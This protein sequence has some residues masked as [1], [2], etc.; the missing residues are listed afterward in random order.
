MAANVE[1]AVL[2][3]LLLFIAKLGEEIAERLGFP[4]FSGSIISGILLSGAVLGFIKPEALEPASLLLV[5]GINFTLFLAGVEELSNPSI[6]RPSLSEILLSIAILS[7][8]SLAIA[9]FAIE[10]LGLELQASLGLGTVIALVSAGP[11]MKLLLAKGSLENS[12][13]GLMR[14]GLL[15][16]VMGLIVFNV[17][18][19]GFSF[20]RL[21]ET[22]VFVGIVFLVGRRMF[23]DFLLFIERH[24]HVKEAPFAFIIALVVMTGYIAELIGFNAA[25]TA[26]LLGAFLSE[27]MQIRPLYLERV[28]AFT[29][30]FL[31]PLFFI[32]IGIYAARFRARDALFALVFFVV[33][34][35]L[36]V[37]LATSYG[38]KLR[39][40]IAF[41]AKGG[42]DVALLLAL[43]QGGLI[44]YDVYTSALLA[45]LASVITASLAYRVKER[46]RD[47]PR[48]RLVDLRPELIIID[49]N[50][51]AEYAARLVAEKGAAVVVDRFMR[52]VGYIVAEDFATVNP[53]MLRRIPVK[54]F[55]RTEVPVVSS[56]TTISEILADPPLLHEPIIA[57]VNHKGEVV[58][59]ITPRKLLALLLS[60]REEHVKRG[61]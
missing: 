9:L 19:Q 47:I 38:F 15:A 13:L 11:L 30:G 31:E 57:I 5:I 40:S 18:I 61:K 12:D 27:Y 33:P 29:Y 51:S 22:V 32:G 6:L 60:R 42:V 24:I 20:L 54:L 23:D 59:T 7:L 34:S 45:I 10:M 35:S 48:Q 55:M 1:V 56:D 2:I 37:V 14:I 46:S 53:R 21:L 36:K 17:L 58:G 52:P 26:L 16:E 41:L 4:G 25:V 3:G 50:E 43:L 39:E 8:P 28:R 44:G 49:E